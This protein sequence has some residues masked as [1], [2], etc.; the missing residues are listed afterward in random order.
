MPMVEKEQEEEERR[1]DKLEERR[2]ECHG[3][4]VVEWWHCWYANG[5]EGRR[6]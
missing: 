3:D 5:R 6:G 2:R 1:K 4:G